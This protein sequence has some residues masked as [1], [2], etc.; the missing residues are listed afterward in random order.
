MLKIENLYCKAGN[1]LLKAATLKVERGEYF[2]LLGP[3]GSGKTTLAKSICGLHRN[4]G[5]KIFL[6]GADITELPPEKRKIGYLPQDFA[7]FP[8]MN[9][10]ENLLFAPRMQKKD[11]K[12][13]K[14]KMDYIAE[15]LDIGG[16]LERETVNLSGGEKQRAALGRALLADPEILI[17][18]EP[19]S[20]IDPGLK[21]N[22]WFE[23]KDFLSV[24]KIPV[25]HITHNLDEAAVLAGKMG[26]LINGEIV[27]QGV[28]E[29][30]FSKPAAAEVAE[31]LGIRN[32]YSGKI[33]KLTN[34]QI[35]IAGKNFKITAFNDKNFIEGE[36]VKF[37]IRAQDIKIMKEN[38]AV[39]DELKN[40]IFEGEIKASHFLSDSC[41]IKVEAALN[42]ELK[43]PAYIYQ[44]HKLYNGKKVRVGIWQKGINVFRREEL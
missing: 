27:Q 24:L 30:I 9:V 10:R 15:T 8:N 34:G 38:F 21:T 22:L 13:I 5:G 18:D 12:E 36:K 7:L 25:I 16:I 29:E 11:M 32:I 17:L 26:V 42:F 40:N 1:F 37:S 14:R 6:N 43:F 19:F 28:K 4:T 33:S 41:I 20:S 31:Y 3:T 39:R 2:V 23:M 44:R 35:V